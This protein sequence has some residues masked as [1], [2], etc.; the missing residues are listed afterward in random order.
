MSCVGSEFLHEAPQFAPFPTGLD[1]ELL[2][3]LSARGVTALYA[4]QAASVT[5]ALNGDHVV[6]VT[7]AASGKTLCYNLPVLQRL[8]NDPAGRALYLFPTKALGHDQLA[9]LIA[10]LSATSLRAVPAAYDGDTPS[11][12]RPKI[13]DSSR[14]VLSNPDMLH[15]GILPQHPR[16]AAFFASLRVV[17]IDEMHVYRGVFGSHVA[18]VLRRLRRICR[19]YG[20]APQFILTSATIANPSELAR[21]LVE[22]AVAVVGARYGWCASGRKARV[23][24]QPACSRRGPG[25]PQ[26]HCSRVGGSRHPFSEHEVQTIVFGRRDSR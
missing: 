23:V 16:W 18:N 4:H 25:D 13:R 20:S 7:P 2:S 8:L 14:I 12:Q 6:V 17:V 10:L 15:T 21:A 22:S 5:A 24:L 19:F 3:A 1:K 26:K 9:G 11:A